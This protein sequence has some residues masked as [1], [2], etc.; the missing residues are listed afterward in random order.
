MELIIKFYHSNYIE[1]YHRELGAIA[2]ECI[3]LRLECEPLK[4]KFHILIF[5]F[6]FSVNDM[7]SD[8][9]MLRNQNKKL[10][11]NKN[12]RAQFFRKIYSSVNF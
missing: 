10:N 11:Q 7:N 5:N 4:L 2:L 9:K 1:K 6:K 3:V 12:T 8:T